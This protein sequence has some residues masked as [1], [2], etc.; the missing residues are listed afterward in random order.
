[1]SLNEFLDGLGKTVRNS[2]RFGP[3]RPDLHFFIFIFLLSIPFFIYINIINYIMILFCLGLG[4]AEL[5]FFYG[6]N[7]AAVLRSQQFGI[8]NVEPSVLSL[9]HT[10]S[11][12][13]S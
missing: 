8:E 2:K 11:P 3:N 9:A 1:M 12:E 10:L 6:A 13:A 5:I 4:A 7:G